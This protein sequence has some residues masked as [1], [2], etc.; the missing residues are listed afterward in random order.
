MKTYH[1]TFSKIG[2]SRDIH[3]CSKAIE[4]NTMSEAKRILK[5]E[6][7]SH[8]FP[9]IIIKEAVCEEDE[10]ENIGDDSEE[11]F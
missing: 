7:Y 10:L 9:I 2:E 6:T 5:K 11:H 1:F 8:E 4:A 3:G